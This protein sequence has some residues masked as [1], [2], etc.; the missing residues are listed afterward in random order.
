[1]SQNN[2]FNFKYKVS[3]RNYNEMINNSIN[4]PS[5]NNDSFIKNQLF[6]SALKFGGPLNQD[7]I[8]HHKKNVRKSTG[9]NC[10][11]TQIIFD[12][13]EI[14]KEQNENKNI[15][16]NISE[17]GDNNITKFNL[18]NSP[19]KKE[20]NSIEENNIFSK[21]MYRDNN[22]N[23]SNTFIFNTQKKI[24]NYFS[25]L[26]NEDKTKNETKNESNNCLVQ[27]DSNKKEEKEKAKENENEKNQNEKNINKSK[28]ESTIIN[29]PF[30]SNNIT[31]N[32][33]NDKNNFT[34]NKNFSFQND[35]I[36]IKSVNTNNTKCENPFFVSSKSK[37]Q[38][39]FKN[40][41]NQSHSLKDNNAEKN[42]TNIINPFSS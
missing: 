29:N 16:N 34:L 26:F 6:K 36:N 5:S 23:N 25:F 18:N 4:S 27:T 3:K 19:E 1:M 35:D 30:I 24:T 40:I 41:F 2:I 8:I 17:I 10:F 11:K 13:N 15:E 9:T 32:D 14:G 12:L 33:N 22:N 21:T 7:L 31:Q 39:P 28:E 38:N 20:R 37:L 42:P